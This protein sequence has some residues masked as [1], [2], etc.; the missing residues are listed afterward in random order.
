MSGLP[1]S[2]IGAVNGALAQA[3]DSSWT[4]VWVA[5]ACVV[6]ASAVASCFF[7]SIAPR[8]NHYIESAD[9]AGRESGDVRPSWH[10]S[11]QAALD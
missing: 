5:M 10:V 6:I 8:M 2:L 1:K 4:F 11:M 9:A 7:K 3:R